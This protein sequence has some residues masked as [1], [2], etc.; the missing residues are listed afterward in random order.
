M[1]LR[2]ASG[3]LPFQVALLLAGLM[4]LLPF[5]SFVHHN[6]V[7]SFYGEWLAAALG[8]AAMTV[9]LRRDVW[10]PFA[11]PRVVWL[12]LALAGLILLQLALGYL[13]A[14]QPALLGVLY[15]LWAA[16]LMVLGQVLRE[17]LGWERLALT[18]SWCLLAGALLSALITLLQYADLRKPLGGLAMPMPGGRGYGNTGQSNHFADYMALATVSLLYLHQRGA[19]RRWL[20]VGMAALFLLML[21]LSGSRSGW[22]YLAAIVVV[23]WMFRASN[24]GLLR[25]ALW[26]LPAFLLLQ[27]LVPWLGWFADWSQMQTPAERLIDPPGGQSVRLYFWQQAWAMFLSAPWLGVGFGQ[28]DWHSFSMLDG[29]APGR[30][31]PPAEHAHNLALHLLAEMG[32]PALL[33]LLAAAVI[34]LRGSLRR[35]ATPETWWMLALL[36]ILGIH[37][38][39]EYPLWYTYFLG[40]AALLLGAGDRQVWRLQLR[41][42]GRPALAAALLLGVMTLGNLWQSYVTLE[43]WMQRGKRGML[44]PQDLGEVNQALLQIHRHSLFAPYV[45]LVYAGSIA[46]DRV[47]LADK[48]ALS[49]SA[50][51]FSPIR[52]VVFRHALLLALAGQPAE[53]LLQLRRAAKAY[54]GD[55]ERFIRELQ[56]M[57][58]PNEFGF[59]LT[60]A[61]RLKKEP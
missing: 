35:D 13:P 53:A 23:A 58:Q 32:L 16:L 56:A 1:L 2:P 26:L 4:W 20:G 40:T 52:E 43:G 54:P 7:P 10:Q 50:Q 38:M 49:Q 21:A 45:E 27:W 30:A 6:P 25:A 5:L 47:A 44:Q 8:L 55:L 14:R 22:L 15:L 48:L 28:Y 39:L 31:L 60:E 37:S 18:L 57:A 3:P 34:W 11:V 19:C 61:Q 36:A 17:R 9:L 59:L 29:I 12:P 41:R 51:R 24:P 46:P 33:A 42:I